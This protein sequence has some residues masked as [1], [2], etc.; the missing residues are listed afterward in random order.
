MKIGFKSINLLRNNE[1]IGRRQ[2]GDND[3]H[4]YANAQ[5]YHTIIDIDNTSSILIERSD[6][7][8]RNITIRDLSEG[9]L[10]KSAEWVAITIIDDHKLIYAIPNTPVPVP[11]L[12]KKN[13]DPRTWNNLTQNEKF[14]RDPQ[15]CM[16]HE[17]E[18]F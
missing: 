18:G 14:Q 7:A 8:S 15:R 13:I 5:A 6:I 4:K 16:D 17:E 1:I 9:T 10:W 12:S 11:V 2:R 3:H